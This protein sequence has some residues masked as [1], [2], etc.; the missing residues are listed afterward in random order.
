[1][2]T[3]NADAMPLDV[4][5]WCAIGAWA[6]LVV[7]WLFVNWVE[8]DTN[9]MMR[10]DRRVAREDM[11]PECAEHSPTNDHVQHKRVE[12]NRHQGDDDHSHGIH[13][14][15]VRPYPVMP[16]PG[17]PIPSVIERLDRWEPKP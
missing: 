14:G 5:A 13:A 10:N 7:V 8:N 3:L 6:L 1:M 16:S 9:R 17:G 4:L 15:R 12:D 11:F 2:N